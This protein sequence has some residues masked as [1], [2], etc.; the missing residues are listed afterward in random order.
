MELQWGSL[1]TGNKLR[2]GNS[3]LPWTLNRHRF[4]YILLMRTLTQGNVVWSLSLREV[5]TS[6]ADDTNLTDTP[7]VL[8]LTPTGDPHPRS[9]IGCR[10]LFIPGDRV[11]VVLYLR[12]FWVQ[13]SPKNFGD[14]FCVGT[15]VGLSSK[16]TGVCS[17]GSIQY[18]CETYVSLSLYCL[19]A[20]NF[21]DSNT[22]K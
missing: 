15:T 1:S 4:A 12:Q 14:Y 17:P 5:K 20:T 10:S 21:D 13:T 7:N 2:E 19:H 6:C 18:T 8:L 11:L 3:H 22:I 16:C 9:K